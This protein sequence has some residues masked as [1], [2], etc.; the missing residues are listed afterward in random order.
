MIYHI[1]NGSIYLEEYAQFLLLIFCAFCSENNLLDANSYCKKFRDL[2]VLEIVNRS[3][4]RFE[5]GGEAVGAALLMLNRAYLNS[6][7][8]PEGE[9]HHQK[10]LNCETDKQNSAEFLSYLFPED[11]VRILHT[12]V[13]PENELNLHIRTL[14]DTQ[15]EIFDIV[16]KWSCS[17]L[18]KVAEDP[19]HI[20]I[21]G[22]ASFG[23]SHLVRVIYQSLKNIL[24]LNSDN[25]EKEKVFLLA[26][27]GVAAVNINGETINSGLAIPKKTNAFQT[28]QLSYKAQPILTHKYAELKILIIKY[29]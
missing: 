9:P 14:N 6:T 22:G 19:L 15:K 7:D 29:L 12:P 1:P 23:K 28:N 24:S 13:L 5:P 26:Q 8:S 11:D 4:T 3:N 10:E 17:I 25:L 18:K 27:A 2:N 21:T 20:F 16:N